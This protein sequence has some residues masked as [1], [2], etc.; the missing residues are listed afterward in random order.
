MM[1]K[2]RLVS[3]DGFDIFDIHAKKV[4]DDDNATNQLSMCEHFHNSFSNLVTNPWCKCEEFLACDKFYWMG[5]ETTRVEK[6][7][8]IYRLSKLTEVY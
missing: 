3:H 6:S 1:M 4:P 2:V 8:F 7:Y 5:N